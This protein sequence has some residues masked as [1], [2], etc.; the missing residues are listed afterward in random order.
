[1]GREL[2]ITEFNKLEKELN[3]KELQ[4]RSLL[5][6]TQA[7]NNNVSAAGLYK[8]YRDFLSWEMSVQKMALLTREKGSWCCV[9]SIEVEEDFLTDDLLES[10][11][12]VSRMRAVKDEDS[13]E[14]REFDVIIP[15]LHKDE[16]IAYALIGGFK[17]EKDLYGKVQFITT[18]T[19]IIAVAIE[20]KRLFNDKL[21][22][23]RFQRELE[24]ASEV[25]RWLLPQ[26][27]PD[28]ERYEVEFFYKP[29]FEVG[30]D[31][32]DFFPVDEDTFYYCIADIS[33]KGVSAALL[34]A[35]F[36]AM[37]KSKLSHAN[38]DL[39]SV[40]K[41]L[42]RTVYEI[43][44]GDK[45][46]TFFLAKVDLKEDLI[47]YVN[48]GHNPPIFFH[49]SRM[50]FLNRGTTVLGAVEKLPFVER[51]E[52]R[53]EQDTMLLNFTDGL[54]DLKNDA[55]EFFSI[56]HL[57]DMLCTCTHMRCKDF[58]SLLKETLE[59]FK[60][61]RDYPDDI[62]VLSFKIFKDPVIIQ[63]KELAAVNTR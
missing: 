3:L 57:R 39:V 45:F 46:I 20:N 37:L 61:E 54:I 59:E 33:G 10:I 16:P 44:L 21:E 22:Q 28:S 47:T 42:N 1:M 58:M 49:D 18:I 41:D 62:A 51:G 14:L 15:V 2:S 13:E 32:F 29:H 43:T 6:I 25:Q 48:A 12:E 53:I 35:N 55:D 8:M 34:M 11:L 63:E 30:G 52:M 40:I 36:Q 23:E 9:S 27:F 50:E 56:D 31:Y 19:N 38:I 60:G 26:S 24:L 5:N 17:D 4:I 7:I